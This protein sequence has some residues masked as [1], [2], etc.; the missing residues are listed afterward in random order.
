MRSI[1]RLVLAATLLAGSALAPACA[2]DAAVTGKLQQLVTSYLKERGRIEDIS[3]VTL[4]ADLGSGQP[5][6]AVYAGTDGHTNPHP[7]GPE[8]LFQ[9]GSNTKHFTAALILMLEAK[10]KLTIDQ[11]V[12]NWLPQY[13]AWKDVTIRSLLNMTAPIPN[14]SE[15]IQIGQIEAADMNHQFTPIEL[16]AAVDPDQGARLPRP[17]GWFYSNTNSML[18]AMIIEKASGM[19]YADA[20]TTMILQ[21]LQLHDTYYSNG[22]YPPSVLAHVPRGI[23]AN[24]ACLDYQPKPCHASV[25]APLIGKDVSRQNLSWAGPAGAMISAPDDLTRWIRALFGLR[26]IPQQQLDEMTQMVSRKTGQPIKDV[27]AGDPAGFGL[28]LGRIYQPDG[29]PFW[30]YEGETLGFRV[31]FAYWPQYDLV[32]TAATNSQPPEGQD[33]L[34]PGVIGAAFKILETAGTI[35]LRAPAQS[36]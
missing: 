11:T 22:A 34:G 9:T 4:H 18:A 15:T 14:Y 21:P 1:A 32:I 24:A 31:M 10:G 6:I 8:T 19:S 26:V 30:F 12:G 7:F 27:S 16:V 20:L 3:G 33:H 23:Y 25:L 28:D 13:P 29:G 35:H 5:E 17:S 2:Q 36:R